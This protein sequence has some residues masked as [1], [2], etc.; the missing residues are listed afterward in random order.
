M[1]KQYIHHRDHLAQ[2]LLQ[3]GHCALIGLQE[4]PHN[5]FLTIRADQESDSVGQFLVHLFAT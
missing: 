1:H 3:S 2:L 4:I 5:R